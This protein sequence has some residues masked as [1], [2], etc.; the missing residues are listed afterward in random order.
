MIPDQGS[1]KDLASVK[2]FLA[3]YEQDQTGILYFR[4]NEVLKVFYLNRGRISWAISSDEEDRIDHVLLA[5]QLVAPEILA[6]YQAGNQLAETFG[7]VLVENGVLTLEGLIQATREQVRRIAVSVMR[8]SVGNHQL[9]AEPPPTR[10]VSLDLEIPALVADFVLTQM[11]VNIA[12]EELGSHSG[13]MQQSTDPGKSRLYELDAEQQEVLSRFREP[14][15]LETALLDFPSERK[16]RIL[17]ILYFL[18]LTGLLTKREGEKIPSL[19]FKELDSLFGQGA[20]GAP[21]AVDIEMPPLINEAEIKDIPLGELPEIPAMKAGDRPGP[22]LPELP[23]LLP[24]EGPAEAKKPAEAPPAEKREEKEKPQARAFLRPEKQKPRWRSVTFLSI[25]LAAVMI[26]AFLWLTRS[27]PQAGPQAVA[28]QDEA[29][30][31]PAPKEQAERPAIMGTT[32][33]A[34]EMAA[35]SQA[36][37]GEASP[38]EDGPA[39]DVPVPPPGGRK[40][41][42]QEAEAAGTASEPRAAGQEAQA[43]K[44]FSAGNFA[45][46][47]EVWR[48]VVIAAQVKFSILLEL[49]CLKESVRNAYRQLSDTENFFL[50]NRTSREGRRCWLVL[51][52]RFRTADEA[53]LGLR[54]VPEY[55]LKQKNPPSV[56]ELAP[57]L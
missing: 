23:D 39:A 52:G 12:W 35:D 4:Q 46:A 21:A 48:Q 26:A 1:L 28:G 11:D 18:L 40:P 56:I 41:A 44:H 17:K 34:Q 36:G 55:F 53:A 5:K 37:G 20:P 2:L 54:L 6:P 27:T 50:L 3:L 49:D 47:G 42:I 19:D 45:A 8:W 10:L 51:W 13:E 38:E 43:R 25:L 24:P 22:E 7:K 14:R 57:Y 29:R 15:R 33:A 31:T 30:E 32:P 9:V 16:S